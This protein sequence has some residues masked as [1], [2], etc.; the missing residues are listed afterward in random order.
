MAEI[1]GIYNPRS[2]VE[3]LEEGVCRDYWNKTGGFSEL[4]E[5]ITM[6]FDGLGEAVTEL[7]AG[8]EISVDVL[9]LSLIHI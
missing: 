5:Y 9:G 7:V 6:N 8:N 4:E 2:V 3:A 1:G